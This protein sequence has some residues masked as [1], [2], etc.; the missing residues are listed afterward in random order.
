MNWDNF[1][2]IS[3]DGYGFVVEGYFGDYYTPWRTL[4]FVVLV[5]LSRK[6]WKVWRN[7]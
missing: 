5:L 3:L 6:A 2:S 4:I 1:F 7:K